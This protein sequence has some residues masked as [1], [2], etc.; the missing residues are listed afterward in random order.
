MIYIIQCEIFSV[1]DSEHHYTV[2]EERPY[3]VD[4]AEGPTPA[5]R[6]LFIHWLAYQTYPY[7]RTINDGKGHCDE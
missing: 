4:N 6:Y 7:E 3:S 5:T 2:K 1:L